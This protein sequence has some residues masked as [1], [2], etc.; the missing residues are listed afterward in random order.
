M[1]L[2]SH[3]PGGPVRGPGT[4]GCGVRWELASWVT[5]GV[6]SLCPPT[7]E[8]ARQLPAAPL[9]RTLIPSTGRPPSCPITPQGPG[10]LTPAFK[11]V[12]EFDGTYQRSGYIRGEGSCGGLER[13]RAPLTAAPVAAE[14]KRRSHQ[15]LLKGTT[16]L[17]KAWTLIR[18][19][20][21][22]IPHASFR[23]A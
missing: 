9:T 1:T 8:E 19:L 5:G 16:W 15:R 3:G 20:S 22:P 17:R 6:R 12:G 4:S 2:P 11:E 23:I 13:V 7:V 14:M 10:P 21:G 18:R